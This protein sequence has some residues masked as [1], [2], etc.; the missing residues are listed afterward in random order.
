MSAAV[1]DV[2]Y[3]ILPAGSPEHCRLLAEFFIATHLEYDPD[4]IAWPPLAQEELERLSRLP[5][6]QEAVSTENVTSNTVTAA[7]ALERDPQLRRAIALQGLEERRHAR[8]LAALTAHYGISIE[9]TPPPH[10]GRARG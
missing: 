1:A 4:G 9:Y 2:P 10:P 7:A 6:W 3:P 8:L 5:F